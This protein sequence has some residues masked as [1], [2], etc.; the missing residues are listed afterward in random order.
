MK[1]TTTVDKEAKVEVVVVNPA[2]SA[3]EIARLAAL[4]IVALVTRQ[5]GKGGLV[6]QQ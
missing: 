1:R 6:H 5:P 3:K 2:I 4:P